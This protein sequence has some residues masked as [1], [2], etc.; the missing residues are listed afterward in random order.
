MQVNIRPSPL[1]FTAIKQGDSAVNRA[2]R[3]L[4]VGVGRERPE[5]TVANLGYLVDAEPHRESKAG[6]VGG[7]SADPPEYKRSQLTTSS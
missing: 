4:A 2:Q 1:P 6:Q 5:K 3:G 7:V